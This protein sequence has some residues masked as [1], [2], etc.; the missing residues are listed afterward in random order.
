MARETGKA[1][2]K[3]KSVWNWAQHEQLGRAV[4]VGGSVRDC[5]LGREPVDW[6]VYYLGSSVAEIARA[7]DGRTSPIERPFK[8]HK[9]LAGEVDA[10]FGRVQLMATE[11]QS[12]P[13]ILETTDWNVS[14]F[15]FD[16]EIH[17]TENV[18]GIA[19]GA[20]LR[21]L[22]VS[23]PIS[24]LARGF[25]FAKRFEMLFD[26]RDVVALCE[27]VASG[28]FRPPVQRRVIRKRGRH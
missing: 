3:L 20:R 23:N 25:D 6:D 12:L 1:E 9:S 2:S 11:L 16:G 14:Q 28:E 24:T 17:G 10:P 15:G 27:A 18:E 21:L 13:E 26:S 7:F 5:I 8:R 4:L 19:K 22:T